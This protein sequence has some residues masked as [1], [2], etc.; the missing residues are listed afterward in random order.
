MIKIYYWPFLGRAG[1]AVRMLREAGVEYEQ[2]TEMADMASKC[3]AFGA[4]TGTI[5]PPVLEDGDTV[6]S[7]STAV[8][9]YVGKKYG[10]PAPDDCKA[11]QLMDDIVDLFQNGLGK[12][13]DDAKTLK[14][15]LDGDGEKPARFAVFAGALERNVAGPYFFG[16]KPSYVDFFFASACGVACLD[17]FESKT[18]VDVLAPYPKLQAI[19]SKIRGLDSMKDSGMI[20]LPDAYGMKEE[21]MEEYA[22]IK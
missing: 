15:Y 18:G 19:A 11:L 17:K 4:E 16:E 12:N 22:K 6:I 7:Q 20:D 14:V 5:A 8:T 21:V 9:M 1:P 10:F 2:I 3:A 13:R